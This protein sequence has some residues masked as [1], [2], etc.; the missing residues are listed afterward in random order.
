MPLHAPNT[1]V[2]APAGT[3]T[4][5]NTNPARTGWLVPAVP[6]P[7]AGRLLLLLVVLAAGAGG[8]GPGAGAG[9]ALEEVAARV[10]LVEGGGGESVWER[11]W[12]LV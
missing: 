9:V 10:A 6:V 5:A 1:Q 3:T 2:V 4:P 8:G 12:W 7:P 11:G